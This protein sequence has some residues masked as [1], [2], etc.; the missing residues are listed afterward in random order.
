M[1]KQEGNTDKKQSFLKDRKKYSTWFW[2]LLLIPI[3][4][5]ALLVLK[6]QGVIFSSTEKNSETSTLGQNEP[7]LT[8]TSETIDPKNLPD[9]IS[10]E[11]AYKFFQ[12]GAYIL[13]VRE[14][15]EWKAGHIP[16]AKL[17]PLGNLALSSGDIP[18]LEP[19]IVVCRSGNRSAQA[20]DLLKSLGFN[21]VTSMA[22]GM[23]DWTAAG[24]ETVTED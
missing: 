20:R 15:Y 16:G 14:P 9:E 8:S 7:K 4:I 21:H 22:G 24:Y 3:I 1:K 6:Q 18:H 19:V 11:Q 2:S 10:V 23:N 12:D 17:I 13:D 5:V